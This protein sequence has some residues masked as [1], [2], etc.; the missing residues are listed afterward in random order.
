MRRWQAAVGSMVF[1][2][3]APGVVVGVTATFVKVYEEPTLRRQFPDEYD[4]Y[5]AA[6]PG[7][8]PRLRPRRR[9]P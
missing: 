1:F 3:V 8:I 4:A 7:W 9:L 6:V 2:A 5:V